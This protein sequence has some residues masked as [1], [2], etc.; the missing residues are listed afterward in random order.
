M[1]LLVKGPRNLHHYLLLNFDENRH[2]PPGKD[3]IDFAPQ[4]RNRLHMD[5]VA[6]AG[7]VQE[8]P[9]C[10]FRR[11]VTLTLAG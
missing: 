4:A 2:P 8:P 9:K 5:K 3:E 1:A 11:R 10:C 6:K 7:G